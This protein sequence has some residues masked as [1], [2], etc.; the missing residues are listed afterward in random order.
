MPSSI[1]HLLKKKIIMMELIINSAVFY[2]DQ[3]CD[4]EMETVQLH[5]VRIM[6]LGGRIT[7]TK[8]KQKKN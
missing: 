7:D 3:K 5:G 8:Q 4:R 6:Q 1:Y 2:G